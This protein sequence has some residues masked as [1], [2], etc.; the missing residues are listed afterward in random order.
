MYVFDVFDEFSLSNIQLL[1]YVT[2]SLQSELILAQNYNQNK[3]AKWCYSPTLVSLSLPLFRFEAHLC[4][5]YFCWHTVN[6][7]KLWFDHI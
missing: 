2:K 5:Y 6:W 7:S 4:Y 3:Q 1:F